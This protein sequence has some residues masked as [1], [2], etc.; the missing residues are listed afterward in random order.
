LIDTK[1]GTNQTADTYLVDRGYGHPWSSTV[2][3]TLTTKNDGTFF[4]K[5]FGVTKFTTPL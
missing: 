2:S 4:A 3:K 5:Y 1:L